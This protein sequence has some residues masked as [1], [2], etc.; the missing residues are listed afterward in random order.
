[1][2]YKSRAEGQAAYD[3]AHR[4]RIA[5]VTGVIGAITGILALVV[6]I[7]ALLRT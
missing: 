6:S 7:V 3:R 4:E 2:V 5:V 1:M